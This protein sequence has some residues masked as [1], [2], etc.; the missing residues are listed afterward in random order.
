MRTS[1]EA[2]L[3]STIVNASGGLPPVDYL[4]SLANQLTII[5]LALLRAEEAE[6]KE[7]SLRQTSIPKID[8]C[9]NILYEIC[10]S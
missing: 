8:A 3:E 1:I 7:L 4:R 2:A 6:G 10:K 5:Q 9:K